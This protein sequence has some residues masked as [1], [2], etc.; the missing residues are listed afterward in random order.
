[1]VRLLI[2]FLYPHNVERK[3]RKM[4]V[5]ESMAAGVIGNASYEMAKQLGKVTVQYLKEKLANTDYSWAVND[6]T[7][8]RIANRINELKYVKGESED[9]YCKRLQNDEHLTNLLSTS[10]LDYTQ[11]N[12]SG[13]YVTHVSGSGTVI[14]T[15]ESPPAAKK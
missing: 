7:I 12:S 1:M 11:Y 13:N 6:A 10:T 9:A 2:L 15:H 8:Q 14:I 4:N 3:R 5:G